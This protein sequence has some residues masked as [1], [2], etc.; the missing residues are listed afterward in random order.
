[1]AVKIRLRQTGKKNQPSQRVV[2]ADARKA[3]NGRFI[4]TLGYKNARESSEKLDLERTEEWLAKGAQPT[5]AVKHMIDRARQGTTLAEK[6]GR[7]E[8]KKFVLEGEA[9]KKKEQPA[10]ESETEEEEAEEAQGAEEA[11]KAE[12]SEASESTSESKEATE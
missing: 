5:S 6:K 4:E 10:A 3:R 8:G 12:E 1:M 2:V 11:E 9:P 7:E